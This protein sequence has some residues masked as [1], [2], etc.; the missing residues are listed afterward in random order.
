MFYVSHEYIKNPPSII[1]RWY[2]QRPRLASAFVAVMARMEAILD[3]L[4]SC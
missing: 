3:G 1:M 2:W 4:T